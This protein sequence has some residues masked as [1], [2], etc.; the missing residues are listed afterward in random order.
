MITVTINGRTIKARSGQSILDVAK[1]HG[2]AIPTLCHL[3]RRSP[4]AVCRICMVEI[5]GEEALAPACSTSI[6]PGLEVNTHSARVQRIRRTLMEL[7]LA[8][9]NGIR[10]ND[11]IIKDLSEQL[12]VAQARFRLPERDLSRYQEIESEYIKLDLSRC[13]RCDRCIRACAQRRVITRAG[14]GI[15][16]SMAFDYDVSIEESSCVQ[17]GDCIQA[18]PSGAIS[19]V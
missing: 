7:T 14:F 4:R 6:R 17:C 13:V 5:V 18:C 19:R 2:I 15:H 9:H 8:E 3:P 10:S 11:P 1:T 12:G 16:V